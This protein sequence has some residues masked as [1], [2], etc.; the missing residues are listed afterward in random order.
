MLM[1]RGIKYY[2]MLPS[3]INS[4]LELQSEAKGQFV[5]RSTL[6]QMGKIV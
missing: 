4:Q 5:G 6:C 3:H 2:Q 1:K